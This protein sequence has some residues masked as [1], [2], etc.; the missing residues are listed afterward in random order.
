MFKRLVFLGPPGVGKGT[1]ARRLAADFSLAHI[2]TGDILREVIKQNTP[3]AERVRSHMERGTLV[4]DEVVLKL[5][6]ERMSRSDVKEGYILDG[7]PRNIKQAYDLDRAG[8]AVERVVYF[9]ADEE[10]LIRRISGRRTCR[11]CSRVY[12]IYYDPPKISGKCEC[13]GELFQRTDDTEDV[14]RA[15]LR[16]YRQKTSTLV[17]HY[18]EKDVLCEVDASGTP[19]EVYEKLLRAI[20]AT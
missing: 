17:Q 20:E 11:L 7:Y 14:V 19:N 8:V 13:G 2:S 12:N 3:L 4:P 9:Y 18:K 1:Q 6:L 10:T 5:L 15:R 16:E